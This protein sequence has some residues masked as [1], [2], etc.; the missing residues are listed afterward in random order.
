MGNRFAGQVLEI[1]PRLA[2]EGIQLNCQLVLCPGLNDGEEELER[3]L[4]DLGKLVPALQSI[5]LG[6]CWCYQIQR[7]GAVSCALIQKIAAGRTID[8]I[9]RF[10]GNQFEQQHGSRISLC[11]RRILFN[12]GEPIRVRSFTGFFSDRKRSRCNGEFER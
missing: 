10:S 7:R 4:T 9:D 8:I 11:F 2:K 1:L 12:S 3:S 6:T 5:A